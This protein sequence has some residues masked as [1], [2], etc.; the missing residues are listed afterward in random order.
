MSQVRELHI[1]R[2]AHNPT[3]HPQLVQEQIRQRNKQVLFHEMVMLLWNT[4][5]RT[6]QIPNQ[7]LGAALDNSIII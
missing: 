2:Q 4:H 5:D 6:R 3:G 1:L 7:H